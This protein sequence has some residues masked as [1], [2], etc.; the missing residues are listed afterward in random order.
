MWARAAAQRDAGSQHLRG[1]GHTCGSSQW[2]RG[3]P[4]DVEAA[5]GLEGVASATLAW[6]RWTSTMVRAIIGEAATSMPRHRYKS[7]GAPP[8]F[9]LD[10]AYG[11]AADM[12]EVVNGTRFLRLAWAMAHVVARCQRT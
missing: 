4:D 1:A 12:G 8:R 10:R 5:I 7:I 2:D 3:A 6:Q 9:R 11:R